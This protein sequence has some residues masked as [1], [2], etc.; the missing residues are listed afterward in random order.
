L[1]FMLIYSI[2]SQIYLNVF[3]LIIYYGPNA[4]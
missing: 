1:L 2:V 4:H 3:Y